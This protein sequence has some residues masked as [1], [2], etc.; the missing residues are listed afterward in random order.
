M[1][2]F[3]GSFVNGPLGR[4]RPFGGPQTVVTT[5]VNESPPGPPREERCFWTVDHPTNLVSISHTP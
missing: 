4:S 5:K 3:G 2:R 1:E